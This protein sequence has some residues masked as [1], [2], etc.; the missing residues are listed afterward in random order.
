MCRLLGVVV[1]QPAPL[2]ELLGDELEP[3]AELACEHGDGWGFSYVNSYGRI[4]TAKEPVSAVQSTTFRL[5]LQR[6]VTSAAI[7]HLRL[8]SPGHKATM[9]NTHP[10]GDIHYGF[11]H[12]GQF[13]P[14]STLDGTL[15]QS[16]AEAM[17][18]TD[19]E[20]YYLAIRRRISEGAAPA[21]AISAAAAD[22]RALAARLE[23]ANCLFLTPRTLYAYADHSAGS[24]AIRR[25][26][27]DF[28]DL[29]YMTEPGRAM[30]ASSG[31]PQSASRWMRQPDRRVAEIGR[32]H[33]H[34]KYHERALTVHPGKE[35]EV[36]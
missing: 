18:D 36:L 22:I 3:F 25:R 9:V 16:L 7:L 1:E 31:W 10:F 33:G 13:T 12:N 26:G 2:A 5:L 17:G 15:G 30:V 29:R 27:A 35:R 6:V 34:T 23:S 24:D 4:V 28:F 20:R 19:S 14:A 8:G 32:D 21:A 11:A